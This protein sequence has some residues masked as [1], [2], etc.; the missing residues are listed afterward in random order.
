MLAGLTA[1][2]VFA[3]FKLRT[4]EAKCEEL[5]RTN[6]RLVSDNAGL[7]EGKAAAEA[8][9]REA[10]E[11]QQREETARRQEERERQRADAGRDLLLSAFRN[12]DPEIDGLTVP[13]AQGL[14]G[15]RGK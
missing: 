7:Y 8:S 15:Q 3:A 13:A 10:Q 12:P 14:K 2:L 6:S 5:A 1:L 11:A 9:Q 4:L